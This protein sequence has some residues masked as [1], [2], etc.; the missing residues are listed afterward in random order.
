[1]GAFFRM[2]IC[3]RWSEIVKGGGGGSKVKWE[4]DF[5]IKLNDMKSGWK[6]I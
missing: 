4:I 5:K 3:V 6:T 2:T 1:M